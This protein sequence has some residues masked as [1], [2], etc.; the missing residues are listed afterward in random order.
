[1]F[2]G[3]HREAKPMSGKVKAFAHFG[4]TL[5]NERWSW[6]GRAPDGKVVLTIWKDEMNY[7]TKPPSC[8]CF[9]H[10]SLSEWMDRPG[11]TERIKDLKW[12]RDHCGGEFSVVITT[13]K[14]PTARVR[15]IDEAYPTKMIMRLTG[16]NEQTG[17]FS[18][19]V[20]AQN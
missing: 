9:G 17:E 11:N 7:K 10:P 15:E 12:A 3:K 1:M 16:L 8:S 6:S 5:T 20:V 2:G 13:A 19:E 14:D 4:V 18:A